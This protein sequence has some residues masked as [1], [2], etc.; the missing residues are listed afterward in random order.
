MSL[1]SQ[2]STNKTKEVDGV[3]IKYAPNKDGTVPTFYL[4][5][6]GKSNKRYEQYLTKVT[7]P[8]ARQLRMGT[9]EPATADELF[10]DVFVKTVL[11]GW[12]NVQGADGVE[13]PFTPEAAT[14]LFRALPDLYDDLTEQAQSAALFRD[15]ENEADA[16]NLPK[17]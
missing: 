5:R 7:K 2:F 11:K 10:L 4:S 1:Y 9:I 16:G 8:Y 3:P 14:E 13:I 6:M 17:S 15:E 12:A